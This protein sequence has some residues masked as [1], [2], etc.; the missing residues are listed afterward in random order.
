M[1]EARNREQ[2]DKAI[3]LC[4]D[5]LYK[6]YLHT[7]KANNIKEV[8]INE[9][10]NIRIIKLNKFIYNVKENNLEKFTSTL[11]ALNSIE[12]T[13]GYIIYGDE[14]G[15]EIYLLVKT[16]VTQV[17][18]ALDTLKNGLM[19]NFPGIEL[20]RIYNEDQETLLSNKLFDKDT[21]THISSIVA[22]PKE[23]NEQ[24]ETDIQG[25]EK[26]IEAMIG[27]N[28][29]AMF[30]AKA[31]DK[32]T[33]QNVRVGL[34]NMY[35]LLAPFRETDF[36]FNESE[37]ENISKSLAEGLTT[38]V[39]NTL[40]NTNG[41]SR[42][43]SRSHT[44]GASVGVTST[45]GAEGSLA[46]CGI[47]GKV[48][49]SIAINATANYS[50]TRGKTDTTS[51]SQSDSKGEQRGTS[52][53]QTDTTGS[54][55]S[56]GRSYSFK[57]ENKNITELLKRIDST[58]ERIQQSEDM[59]MFNFGAYFLTSS[60]H[61]S[62]RAASTY[63]GII[64][65]KGSGV[66]NS[67]MNTWNKEEESFSGM[68]EALKQL[69]H[70]TFSKQDMGDLITPTTMIS[71]QELARGTS[72]PYQSVQGLPVMQFIPFA[73]NISTYEQTVNTK[74]N[75]GSIFHMGQKETTP[76][77]IDVDSLTM[78]TFITGS[79]GSGKTNA[80][81]KLIDE[82]TKKGVKVLIIE[83]AK[84]EY[85]DV[86]GGRDDF[87]VY[88]SNPMITDVLQINPFSFPKDIH[89]LEHIDRL[90]EIFSACWPLYAAM[91][92]ILKE[93]IEVC[94][95]KSGWDL[96]TSISIS[97][98]YP[99]CKTLLEVLPQIINA[100]AYSDELKSN[101]IGSLVTRVKSLTN[102]L[103]GNMLKGIDTDYE[104]LFD[105]NVIIDLS[106]VGSMETKAL[107]M[108]MIFLKLYE[109]RMNSNDFTPRLKHL[110]VLEEAHNLLR[111]SQSGSSEGN[112]VQAKSVEMI[113]NGIAEMRAYGEGFVIVD[114]APCIL[115][116]AAIRNTNTKIVL[117]LPDERDRQLVGKA[118]LLTDEQITEI[119]RLRVG[120][121]AIFQ[122][123]WLEPILCKMDRHE[124]S[125]NYKA[126]YKSYAQL[127]ESKKRLIELLLIKTSGEL[128]QIT[129]KEAERL[130]DYIDTQLV[131]VQTRNYLKVSIQEMVQTQTSKS[132]YD[133]K[134][135]PQKLRALNEL[136][137]A[138]DTI[139]RAVELRDANQMT[140]E[141][142]NKFNLILGLQKE[143]TFEL[144]RHLLAYRA[145]EG[146]NLQKQI[147]HEWV[148][149]VQGGKV[150]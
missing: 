71:C 133:E 88:G 12:A 70:P 87:K 49:Q 31:V 136:V 142:V 41:T 137:D 124:K 3:D 42:A 48:T 132:L 55:T 65:G 147:Y 77:N 17:T 40:T 83:P 6:N 26:F 143:Q 84:G 32:Q 86:F 110:T 74:I 72:F 2:L 131:D 135:A 58:L 148:E 56:E 145:L 123:N 89:V 73:R 126:P 11:N 10:S 107:M 94:Y 82:V 29:T 127:N 62:I 79:T 28:Y 30:L 141:L 39:T 60:E 46:P 80:T 119:S 66:E 114:Q 117:R 14:K 22:I 18:V 76:V 98:I 20:E 90:I 24:L 106:R 139:Q 54:A 27:E 113:A 7:L 122:N 125:Y 38:S 105:S 101:Y 23:K 69:E 61:I 112:N 21:F 45:T 96:Q 85:K 44:L 35:T 67:F 37:S 25:I 33:L 75:L 95:E 68:I 118:A 50:H 108:G 116:D 129:E 57:A 9:A 59:G 100:S 64:K 109:Y 63:L 1:D 36:S 97:G 103:V 121:A 47:G 93:A 146:E 4:G 115:D 15:I 53:T 140:I 52:N 8:A 51:E 120:V 128:K 19:G 111:K 144:I 5:L 34:E 78:H 43:E 134:K 81:C 102:G 16:Q 99:T 138:S 92:A 91:P 130:Y 104:V 149:F 13:L 150:R